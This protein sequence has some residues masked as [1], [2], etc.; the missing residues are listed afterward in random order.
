[1]VFYCDQREKRQDSWGG[2]N[3][4]TNT[5]YIFGKIK[6]SL[7]QSYLIICIIKKKIFRLFVSRQWIYTSPWDINEI[8]KLSVKRGTDNTDTVLVWV[9]VRSRKIINV[10]KDI[11]AISS[12]PSVSKLLVNSYKRFAVAYILQEW[13]V[14]LVNNYVMTIH[15]I[16]KVLYATYVRWKF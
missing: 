1:M 12:V 9:T 5:T 7:H 13:L 2:P 4:Y 3:I 16:V 15:F 11:W 10:E 8:F 6:F 14:Y